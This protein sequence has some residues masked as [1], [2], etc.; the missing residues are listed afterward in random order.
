MVRTSILADA[1]NSINNADSMGKRQV[2][3][4]P[5]SKVT[6]E[7]LNIMQKHGY[8]GEFEIVDDHRSG[9]IVVQLNGR[10]V[11]NKCGVIS[12]RYNIKISQM[13]KWV[14]KL[15]PARQFGHIVLTTS[16]GV[17]DHQTARRKHVSGKI[18]GFFY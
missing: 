7:F 17:M 4:R 15:L 14:T 3:V 9:K 1:M 10:Q 12:P 6:V 5:A 13:E 11:L 18:L 8:I 16:A 2:L